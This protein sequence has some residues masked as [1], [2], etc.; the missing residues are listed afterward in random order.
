MNQAETFVQ[1]CG[2]EGNVDIEDARLMATSWYAAT[3]DGENGDLFAMFYD[4]SVARWNNDVGT[5]TLEESSK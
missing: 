3:I 2:L 4:Y 1:S 5:W